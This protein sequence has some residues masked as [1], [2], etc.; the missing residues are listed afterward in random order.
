MKCWI[1]S[2]GIIEDQA[3]KKRLFQL[4]GPKEP[5]SNDTTVA[6]STAGPQILVSKYYY[7]LIGT[8]ILRK[9]ADSRTEIK[10]V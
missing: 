4:R 6:M 10:K 1:G 8:G 5:R 3:L 2:K 7:S 9:M